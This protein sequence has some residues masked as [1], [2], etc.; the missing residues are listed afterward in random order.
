MFKFV[1]CIQIDVFILNIKLEELHG[2]K[3]LPVISS[4]SLFIDIKSMSILLMYL[5]SGLYKTS[6]FSIYKFKAF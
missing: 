2:H 1:Q 4:K 6:W 5:N 3:V